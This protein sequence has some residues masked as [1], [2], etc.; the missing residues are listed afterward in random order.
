MIAAAN[1]ARKDMQPRATTAQRSTI[2]GVMRRL[3]LDTVV[4]TSWHQRYMEKAGLVFD[5]G[6]SIDRLLD[7]LT[8]QQASRLITVLR[9]AAE[10]ASV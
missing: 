6:M 5:G 8:L 10:E 3:E 2:R 9:E 1:S 7:Q 4:V